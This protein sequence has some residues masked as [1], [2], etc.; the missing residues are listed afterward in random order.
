MMLV[1]Q[2]CGANSFSH[3]FGGSWP[4][5]DQGER[6]VEPT[7]QVSF[8]GQ[9]R[10][11]EHMLTFACCRLLKA[12]SKTSVQPLAAEGKTLAILRHYHASG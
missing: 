10:A 12:S 1:S 9:G 3:E 7:C 2:T 11:D 6:L 5:I 8:I 4:L